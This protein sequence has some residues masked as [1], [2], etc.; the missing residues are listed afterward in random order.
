MKSNRRKKGFTL[1]EL[2]VAMTVAAVLV[3]VSLNVYESFCHGVSSSSINYVR[4]AT[5]QAKELRCRTRFV[6]GLP[7]CDSSSQRFPRL[8]VRARF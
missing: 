6:R 8:D 7:P 1:M 3:G 4:F 5:E 2:L